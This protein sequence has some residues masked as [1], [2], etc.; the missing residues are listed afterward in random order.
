MPSGRDCFSNIPVSTSAKT[1]GHNACMSSNPTVVLTPTARLARALARAAALAQTAAGKTAWRPVPIL[2]FPA[3]LNQLREDYFLDADDVRTP[4]SSDQAHE[5]WKSVI[6]TDIFIGEPRVADLAERAWHLLH[7]HQLT[8]PAQWPELLMN[9][10]NRRFRDWVR[11]YQARCD[12]KRWVDQTAWFSE[13]PTLIEQ[14]KI[15]PPQTLELAGFELPPTPLQQRVIDACRQSGSSI[16]E[17]SQPERTQTQSVDI[18]PADS[19]ENELRAAAI[20]ARQRLEQEPHQETGDQRIAIV[21]PNLEGRVEQAEHAMRRIFD[22]NGF[23]LQAETAEPWHISLG[24]PL[25]RWPLTS[26]ALCWL[27]LNPARMNQLDIRR[28]L[29]SPFMRG[30][31][32]ET[33]ARAETVTRLARIAPFEL[34]LF[35][36]ER[37]LSARA[38]EFRTS[39]NAW[40]KLR[41]Q[42]AEFARPSGW[43][44]QFQNELTALGFGRGRPLNSQEHQLLARWQSLLEAFSALDVVIEHPIGRKTALRMLTERAGRQIFRERNP[45]VPVEVLG[46]KEALGSSFDAVWVTGMAT[47]AWPPA[48][49]REP[50]IPN[51]IQQE[52]VGTTSAGRL[53]LAQLELDTLLASASE[54]VFSFN[55]DGEAVDIASQL[56]P[57]LAGREQRRLD[58]DANLEPAA[59]VMESLPDQ[60][61]APAIPAG[62][63]HGGT[64]L[65][66]KQSDC[67]FRAFAE[68]RLKAGNIPAPRPGLDAGVR[69]SLVHKALE[70]LWRELPNAQIL[71]SMEDPAIQPIIKQVIEQAVEQALNHQ[72]SRYRLAISQAG[73]ALEKQRLCRLLTEWIQLEKK[74]PD[75]FVSAREYGVEIELG[76]VRT[77][78][79]IDRIDQLPSMD[80]HNRRLLIDYKTGSRASSGHWYPGERMADVQLPAY[81][82]SLPEPPDAIA[83]ARLRAGQVAFDGI[84]QPPNDDPPSAIQGLKIIGRISKQHALSTIDSWPDLLDDWRRHLNHL[85][86]Q[87]LAGHAAVDPREAQVCRYC[88]LHALCR[89]QTRAGSANDPDMSETT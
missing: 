33:L 51:T 6:D 77:R 17:H 1:G 31:P 47:D 53:A 82:L 68:I 80:G 37:D 35:E 29:R 9:T 71:N 21:V 58:L 30:W 56:T 48:A 78:G 88:H 18:Y 34:T 13:I 45:G 89:I 7:E 44:T 25:S 54:H 87:F 38:P 8:P 73:R 70:A 32:Q 69:G 28:W 41:E 24:K 23:R 60:T 12:K 81:A 26:D 10:D 72:F 83:F 57:M 74:R 39:L 15:V 67:P 50:L 63:F 62:E 75:F 76:G 3:W 11:A 46:L 22:P 27:G 61:T 49:R 14:G 20:W 40:R 43:T 36:L 66:Q 79:M 64:G 16:V 42:A 4:I 5:L 55:S 52:V 19:E 2:A 85:G 84:A 86:R 59:A 65:F